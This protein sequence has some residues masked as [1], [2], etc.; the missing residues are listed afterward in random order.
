[1]IGR[2]LFHNRNLKTDTCVVIGG[3]INLNYNAITFCN[4]YV[5]HQ[6]GIDEARRRSEGSL[7]KEQLRRLYQSTNYVPTIV[8]LLFCSNYVTC[9]FRT[10]KSQQ[11]LPHHLITLSDSTAAFHTKKMNTLLYTSIPGIMIKRLATGV[12]VTK[13][14]FLREGR[15]VYTEFTNLD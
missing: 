6:S 9:P 4:G 12:R 10:N 2:I 13:L 3:K 14:R 7:K 11:I 15:I 1:M 5:V 8:H